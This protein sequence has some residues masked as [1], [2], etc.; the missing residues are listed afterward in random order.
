MTFLLGNIYPHPPTLT[1]LLSYLLHSSLVGTSQLASGVPVSR[2]ITEIFPA[3]SQ[4]FI[5]PLNTQ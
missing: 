2:P 3:L 1:C 4:E 5:Y